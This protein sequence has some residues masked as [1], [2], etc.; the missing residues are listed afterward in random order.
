MKRKAEDS[1]PIETL[2]DAIAANNVD[3]IFGNSFKY[4]RMLH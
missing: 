2:F 4:K 1:T 3:V